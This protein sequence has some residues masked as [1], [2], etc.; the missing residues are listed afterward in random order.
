MSK[1]QR[2]KGSTG[3]LECCKLI[4]EIYPDAA[5]ELEQYQVKL[6]R[7]LRN[8]GKLC[9]QVKRHKTLSHGAIF[10][11]Y[12]EAVSAIDDTYQIPVVFY[13]EDNKQ[14]RVATSFG[15]LLWMAE[16]DFDAI[17]DGDEEVMV[18]IDAKQFLNWHKE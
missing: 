12:Q 7:D 2:T 4:S 14:W 11:A 13:R 8:T 6:G 1:M 10:K 17:V 9:I 16:F 18:D 5:R 15:N 3:E